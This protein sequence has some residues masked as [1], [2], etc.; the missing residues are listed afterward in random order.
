[1]SCVAAKTEC[2]KKIIEDMATKFREVKADLVKSGRI[3]SKTVD[4]D[5][6]LFFA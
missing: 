5:D 4:S 6:Y 3:L 1:M 2:A